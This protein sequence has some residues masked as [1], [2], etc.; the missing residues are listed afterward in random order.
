MGGRWIS[1][2]ARLGLY[3]G[4]LDLGYDRIQARNGLS[5][6]FS[7]MLPLFRFPRPTTD[8]SKNFVRIYAEPGLGRRWGDGEFG[9]YSSAK[10]MIAL[11]ADKRIKGN[12][13]SP[14]VE[15]QRRFPFT[16][17]LNGDN[18]VAIGIL[19]IIYE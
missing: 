7:A 13:F 17:P 11:L 3:G 1:A 18:R 12:G 6:E 10:V 2:G 8:E 19:W 4:I 14:F 16:S 15:F 9:G 5:F